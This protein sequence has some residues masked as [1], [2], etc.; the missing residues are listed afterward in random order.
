[1]KI[2]KRHLRRLIEEQL[3]LVSEQGVPQQSAESR[4]NAAAIT[5]G[6]G[7]LPLVSQKSGLTLAHFYIDISTDATPAIFV[8]VVDSSGQEEKFAVIP[9][10]V[11]PGDFPYLGN[12]NI[13]PDFSGIQSADAA[14]MMEDLSGMDEVF[15]STS[16][17]ISIAQETLDRIN[18]Y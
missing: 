17:A 1:M 11:N 9:Q 10:G 13:V 16:E 14:I 2:T 5:I 3:S 6:A 18:I 15:I 4:A 12:V 7:Y 8:N